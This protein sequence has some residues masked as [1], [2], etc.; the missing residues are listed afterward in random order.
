MYRDQ[1]TDWQ[2]RLD[3]IVQTMRDMSLQ[4]DPQAMVQSYI[5]RLRQ[6]LQTDATI[7]LSRRG[8]PAPQFRIT[9]FTGWSDP[10]NPW[11]EPGR[12]PLFNGGILGKLIHANE[13]AIL[14]D[15][16]LASD[17]PA[18]DFIGNHRSLMAIPLFDQG[19]SLNMVISLNRNAGA[20]SPER[21]PE[22]V[23]MSNLFGKAANTL[24]LQQ[25]LQQAYSRIEREM[26]V[27]ADIQRSLLASE[28]P[29]IPGVDLAV[30]YQTS[31]QAGG[32]YYDFLPLPEGRWGILMADVSGHGTPAAVIMAIMHGIVHTY[33]GDPRPPG[34][35]LTYVNHHLAAR[36]TS[37]GTFV[38]AFYG[39][40]DP[41]NRSLVYASAGH[42]APRV[43]SRGR[44]YEITALNAVGNLPLGISVDVQY[45]EACHRFAPGD[46]VLFYTDGISEAHGPGGDLFGVERID[47]VLS[48][49][50]GHSA[51]LVQSL[52]T[53]VNTFTGARPP[54]DDRTL[55][56][57]VLD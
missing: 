54:D 33:P 56:A 30:H 20:F 39:I 45:E 23:W 57:A 35:L 24:V 13:P 43:R 36:Y 15:L 29:K 41:Q 42:P 4:T 3:H 31:R 21:L 22:L 49:A 7:S 2:S 17:D 28:L 53:A 10:P 32:D 8:L 9:R 1:F 52:L 26:N 19:V 11:K 47:E 34:H 27:V 51:D 12:L 16:H 6:L 14:D 38:T 5:G 37:N 48:R 40:Y 50:D 25:E 46:Q 55:I 44:N 18:R